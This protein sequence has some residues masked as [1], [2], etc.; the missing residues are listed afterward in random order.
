M[1]SES[2]LLDEYGLPVQPEVSPNRPG[3][4]LPA[5]TFVG[6]EDEQARFREMML[7]LA[8]SRKSFLGGLRGSSR[9]AKIT[10]T[11]KSWLIVI[12]GPPGSGKTRLAQRLRELAQKE[13]EFSG[14]FRTT[15][16]DWQELFERDN[17]LTSLLPGEP[18]SPETLLDLLHNHCVR[19]NGAGYFEEYRQALEDTKKLAQTVAG[20]ELRAVGEFRARALGR[21]LLAWSGE[22]YLLFFMDNFQL[23]D[24]AAQELFRLLM[25]ESGPQVL[26][27]LSG[28]EIPTT[29]AEAVAPARLARFQPGPFNEAELRHFYD[30]ELARYEV[31]REA[32]VAF[33]PAYRSPDL[34]AQ[35]QS[36]TGGYPLPARFSA[37]LLQTGLTVAN[38]PAGGPQALAA[39]TAQ[40][41]AGPLSA[42]HPDRLRLYALA[43]LRRP[44]TGLLGAMFDTR[45]DMLPVE[46]MLDRLNE[47]YTFL[48]EPG[49]PMT[50][51]PAIV[52]PLRRWLLDPARRY[53]VNALPRLNERALSYLDNRLSEWGVNF[54]GLRDQANDL[55]W[56]DWSLDRVWHAFWLGEEKGWPLALALL[57][58]GLGLRPSLARQVLVL[59]DSLSTLGALNETGRHRLE[60][61][62]SVTLHPTGAG[63]DLRELRLMGAEGHFFEIASPQ[64]ALELTAIIDK[65]LAGSA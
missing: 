12:E 43:T 63:S 9:P 60:L 42:G 30:L 17:R 19:D 64:Y 55:K 33:T 44:E 54:P 37:F 25:E 16:L 34:I 48:F 7:Q 41:M 1:S 52:M 20:D 51:H 32:G 56:R 61:F 31:G 28:E 45:Q 23:L 39:F 59:L 53:E 24:S 5:G 13:K 65:M 3:K 2:P 47:R 40:F 49:R 27:T 21:G 38:L 26:Y 4:Q 50:L 6:R 58:A 18:L 22:R 8:G 36:I 46:E 10:Q 14:R 29:L 57:V 35:L 62:K 11:V 15:R